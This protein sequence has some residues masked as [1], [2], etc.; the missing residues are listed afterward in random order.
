MKPCEAGYPCVYLS[1]DGDAC[2]LPRC[3]LKHVTIVGLD[4][5]FAHD[6]LTGRNSKWV[7][8]AREVRSRYEPLTVADMGSADTYEKVNG[9]IRPKRYA[10]R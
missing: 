10:L 4:G 5:E 7:T 2:M 3:V 9:K 6:E 1:G 8:E